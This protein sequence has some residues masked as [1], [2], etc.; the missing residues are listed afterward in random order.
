MVEGSSLLNC[1]TSNSLVG[2]NPTRSVAHVMP[3]IFNT[4]ALFFILVVVAAGLEAFGDVILKKW[5]LDGKN[6]VFAFGL[7]VYFASTV[8]W[9]YSLKYEFLSKAISVVTIL[10][11]IIVVLVGVLYFNE[12]LTLLNKL[13]I[14][15]GIVSVILIEL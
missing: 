10:N 5:A 9:A 2:S 11:L 14:L 13:G 6:I 12:Q 4:Q 1:Q 15:L 8:I 3:T 7:L